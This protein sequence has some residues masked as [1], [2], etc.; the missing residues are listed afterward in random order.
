MS[1]RKLILLG[2][3]C[4]AVI[5]AAGEI[6]G[7]IMG[8]TS[9]VLYAPY[10]AIEYILKPGQ[11]VVQMGRRTTANEYGMRSDPVPV[12]KAAGEYRVLALGDSVL[13]GVFAT[14]HGQLATTILSHDGT[15]ILNASANGWGPQNLK[16]YID[17]FGTFD[18]DLLVLVLNSEDAGDVPQFGD[19]DTFVY[20]VSRP[21]SALY[22]GVGHYISNRLRVRRARINPHPPIAPEA[23]Q[24]V[25][26][27]VA[28]PLPVCIILHSKRDEIRSGELVPG[29]QAI[30][31]AGK[32]ALIVE[33][34][35]FI[36]PDTYYRDQIHFNAEG[37][38]ALVLALQSCLDQSKAKPGR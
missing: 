38:K 32:G 13:N 19:L 24:A 31:E 30:R 6:G 2:V 14:D 21:V 27:M 29:L 16:G 35:P 5:A 22:A 17:T 28:L 33:D 34:A 12:H 15:R 18:A 20:P 25:R 36:N 11:N 3:I 1:V 9:P 26:D 7:R 8:L 4:A 23:V 10:P 37:Q